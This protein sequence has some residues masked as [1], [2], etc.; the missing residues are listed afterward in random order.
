MKFGFYL[1][2]FM[3][4]SL[5]LS[6]VKATETD[7]PKLGGANIGT[8]TNDKHTN[9]EGV[10][11]LAETSVPPIESTS[12]I[13]AYRISILSKHNWENPSASFKEYPSSDAFASIVYDEPLVD[14]YWPSFK[15]YHLGI[16]YY[17]WT[18]EKWLKLPKGVPDYLEPAPF[19]DE[20]TAIEF[21]LSH[22]NDYTSS[23]EFICFSVTLES[24]FVKR[25]CEL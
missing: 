9:F 23:V 20:S 12:N 22:F 3:A 14:A 16:S 7:P 21:K 25:D 17:D 11:S 19:T 2:A 18:F 10:Y 1:I 8:G 4:L 15:T 24:L 5:S 13:I 6:D